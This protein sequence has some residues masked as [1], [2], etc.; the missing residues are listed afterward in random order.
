MQVTARHCLHVRYRL[1]FNSVMSLA[2]CLKLTVYPLVWCSCE[3][4]ERAAE[5]FRKDGFVVVKEC[6]VRCISLVVLN[7]CS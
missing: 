4:A 1:F 7:T 5:I 3:Y 2:V 6:L